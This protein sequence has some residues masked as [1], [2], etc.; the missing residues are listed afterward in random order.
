MRIV[1][2]NP[3]H[4]C[5][6]GRERHIGVSIPLACLYISAA[7]KRARHEVIILDAFSYGCLPVI[8]SNDRTLFYSGTVMSVDSSVFTLMGT[9]ITNIIDITRTYKPDVVGLSVT[10]SSLHR[11]LPYIMSAFRYYVPK[12][13]LVMG[14]S[15]ITAAPEIV[16]NSVSNVDYLVTGEGEVSFVKLLTSI[17]EGKEPVNIPG[18]YYRKDGNIYSSS[19]ELIQNLDNIYPPDYSGISLEYYYALQG[20]NRAY[21]LTSRGCPF[22]C[23]FCT[24]PKTCG[25]KWRAHSS[26]RVLSEL[27]YMTRGGVREIFFEDDNMSVNKDRFATILEGIIRKHWNLSLYVPQGL[28]IS[29]LTPDILKMMYLAG[30]E[31]V[32][33]SPETGNDRVAKEEIN[34][35]FL[36]D[37]ARKVV[38]DIIKARMKPLVNLVVGMPNERWSEIQDTVKYAR[39]LKKMGAQRF[40]LSMATPI[41]GS[42]MFNDLVAQGRIENKVPAFIDYYHPS[43][44]G[45][46][47]K[48][49]ELFRLCESLNI[50]L[51]KGCPK[52]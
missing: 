43:F 28:H 12:A 30:F 3:W 24:V 4:P 49:E 39:E 40:N 16:M 52:I 20:R 41:I 21:M 51:N 13:K 50:E 2:I 32:A 48:S 36:P 38:K 34:K 17:E 37:D 7:A 19:Y 33:V 42:R 11:L 14:G 31:W 29:T 44:D 5:I 22:D 10:F 47:W 9:A 45:I 26:E 8:N 1:L 46:D 18:I 23:N 35:T 15:H 6:G 25:R 27:A